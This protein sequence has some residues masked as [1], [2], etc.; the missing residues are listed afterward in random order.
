MST[1]IQ[2]TPEAL[3]G[4]SGQPPAYISVEVEDNRR[5]MGAR[6]RLQP[7][8]P[9]TGSAPMTCRVPRSH[10]VHF[11]IQ[12]LDPTLLHIWTPVFL[13]NSRG[14]QTKLWPTGTSADTAYF[15]TIIPPD[16]YTLASGFVISLPHNV[17]DI[18]TDPTELPLTFKIQGQ[19]RVQ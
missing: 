1:P 10:K 13:R 2:T 6:V 12:G 7:A 14:G 4:L 11:E 15:E 18:P 8:A 3:L 19:S 5:H 16:T 17:I 9:G